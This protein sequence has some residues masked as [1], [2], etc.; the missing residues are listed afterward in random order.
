MLFAKTTIDHFIDDLA[1]SR[2][3]VSWTPVDDPDA[4]I[5]NNPDDSAERQ[6]PPN[7][8]NEDNLRAYNEL[9]ERFAEIAQE[10]AAQDEISKTYVLFERALNGLPDPD[11]SDDALADVEGYDHTAALRDLDLGGPLDHVAD[12]DAAVKLGRDLTKRSR[13]RRAS[14]INR[15]MSSLA[16]SSRDDVSA[17]ALSRVA[18][19]DTEACTGGVRP[20]DLA[21]VAAVRHARRPPRYLSALN[22]TRHTRFARRL[23]ARPWR[24]VLFL[25]WHLARVSDPGRKTGCWRTRV[26]KRSLACHRKGRLATTAKIKLRRLPSSYLFVFRCPPPAASFLCSKPYAVQRMASVCSPPCV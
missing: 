14:G 15:S 13:N 11:V 8:L 4:S 3:D 5:D 2:V 20:D 12:L 1:R 9:Q 16:P 10:Q 17:P 18:T 26:P 25:A 19:T 23:R 21:Q 7:P 6:L 24:L 22:S